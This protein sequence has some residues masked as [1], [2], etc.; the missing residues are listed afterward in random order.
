MT[1]PSPS[2]PYSLLSLLSF[3]PFLSLPV[4]QPTNE[5]AGQLKKEEGLLQQGERMEQPFPMLQQVL[6]P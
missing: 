6:H 4:L 3:P 5:G 2:P 1:T